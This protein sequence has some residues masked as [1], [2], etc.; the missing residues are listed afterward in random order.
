MIGEA[1]V[2]SPLSHGRFLHG[3]GKGYFT[4]A[5]IVPA[6]PSPNNWEQRSYPTQELYEILPSYG[7]VYD[8]YISQNRFYGP[9]A[10]SRLAQLSAMY[11]DIDYYNITDL[12]GMHPRSVMDLAFEKLQ[13]A[14]IPRPSLV[15]ATG[16][17]LALV[18]RHEPV[19]RAALA[20]WKF[21][22][23]Y[24]F[25]ALKELGADS[26][27]RDAARVLRLVG[28][29]NSKSGDTVEPLWEEYGEST[30]AFGDLADEILPLTREKLEERRA[31]RWES[32]EKKRASKDTRKAS[33]AREDVEKRFTAYTLALG[34][35]ADLQ[36]LM[37]QRGLDKLPPGQRDS[38]MFAAGTS[39]AYLVEPQFLER[40]LVML[41]KDHAGWGEAETRSRMHSVIRRAKD[42]GAGETIEWEGQQR[43][44][45]YRIT[46]KKI[47]E[48]L[49]ITLD[50]EK[51]MKVLISDQTKRQRD[52][53]RKEQKRR[54]EGARPRQE[55]LA[56][57]NEK[58]TIAQD[59][60]RQGLS[61]R[62]IGEKL[63]ISRTKARRLIADAT[64]HHRKGE[65]GEAQ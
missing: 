60:R 12:D 58:R 24:I 2:N 42:A 3:S 21:C 34:R 62:R 4:V 19:P 33:K 1:L 31:Q 13:R 27:A 47:I 14:Q 37:G 30:W 11:A 57:A 8:A 43:D 48:D 7:G 26:S 49:G 5:R 9:R 15:A 36:C 32:G 44:P 28:S 50:E 63:G 25:E 6:L 23:D 64:I 22:Q 10:V 46:N 55:Y 51:E 29:R 20:K 45:R 39:L 53:E 61:Y 35:L 56:K 41:G 54:I 17:G 16:R 38:W 65:S 59:L 52:R 40:E 18:W